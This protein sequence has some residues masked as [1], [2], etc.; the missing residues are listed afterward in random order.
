MELG[1]ALGIEGSPTDMFLDGKGRITVFSEVPPADPSIGIGMG[2]CPVGMGFRCGYWGPMTTKLTLVD[3]RDAAPLAGSGEVW[4]AGPARH[5]R[6]A[7]SQVPRV[8]THP[9]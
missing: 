6:R 7:G 9:P 1:D 2:L 5:S 4:L 8:V 3:A